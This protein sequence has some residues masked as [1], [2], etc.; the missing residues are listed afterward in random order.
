MRPSL[1]ARIHGAGPT[2][3]LTALALAQAGWRVSL[4]DPLSP[5]ALQGRERA[6]AFTHSSRALLERLGLWGDLRPQLVPF[7]RLRLQD[8]AT[9]RR[10]SF[11]PADLNNASAVGWIGSHR[12]LMALLLRRLGQHPA[13]DLAL[14]VD[15]P[16]IPGT[17]PDL[18]VAADG[19][20]SPTRRALRIGQWSHRYAQACLTVQ[21]EMGGGAD[22]EAW[23]LLR[24]EG[25]FAVLPLG[26]RRF[27][28]VWSA[29]TARCRQLEALS[30]PA[31]LDRLAG[32]LPDALQP[33]ALLAQPRS[34]P[35]ALQLARRLH[36]GRAVLVGESAHRCHP[37][38]G[39]G[40]NLCWRDVAM[41]HQ[42]AERAAQGRLHPRRLAAAY[43][44]RRWP[45][46]LLTLLAT[47]L[48]VRLFS[49]RQ[50][51][52][53][54]LRSL[55]FGVLSRFGWSRALALQVMTQGPCRLGRT[56]PPWRDGD[57]QFSPAPA[58]SGHDAL[59][60]PSARPE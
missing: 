41:L 34:F 51:L 32:A 1:H 14:G 40:L 10:V 24:P 3:A 38:G 5:E 26:E 31:F 58:L 57:Q 19:P 15:A 50:P 6:Y 2:G 56:L 18:L 39:Q 23:E 36:R 12:P 16:P 7:R 37:V 48:L 42:L 47:D 45:D 8:M 54:P 9:S 11:D 21:V 52:L 33:E 17:E 60:A 30:G 44:R 46:L 29:P 53:L 59:P 43:A 25:P 35:V 4:H 49:N 13:I 28:L 55:A 20:D 22:D 27:Q